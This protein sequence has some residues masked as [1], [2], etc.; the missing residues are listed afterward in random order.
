M[1]V[2]NSKGFAVS[3]LLYGL[4]IMG[5]LIVI[6]L[7]SIVSSNRV[8]TKNF[9]N[10]I[11]DDLNRYS[12]TE[13]S[14]SSKDSGDLAQEYFVPYGQEGWYKIELWGAGGGG[15]TGGKGAY[16]SGLIY[17]DA[18]THLYFYIGK[19]GGTS[20]A[21][22]NNGGPASGGYYGGGGETDVRLESGNSND[23]RS[24]KT[25]IMVAA[26]GGGAKGSTKGG[27]GG[28]LQGYKGDGTAGSAT[29]NAG[30]LPT[31]LSSGGGGGFR[32]GGAGEGGSSYISGYA[33]GSSYVLNPQKDQLGEWDWDYKGED[34]QLVP[35][36]LTIHY[37]YPVYKEVGEEAVLDRYDPPQHAFR[38]VN[39]LMI[40]GV[41]DGDGKANI[42]RVDLKGAT[43]LAKKDNIKLSRI[44]RIVD[45]VD[46]NSGTWK[47]IQAVSNGEN[48]IKSSGTVTGSGLANGNNLKDGLLNTEASIAGSVAEKC[49]T[50]TFSTPQDLDEIA[51][52]HKVGNIA[53]HNLEVC[54][55]SGGCYS[56]SNRTAVDNSPVVETS[57]G[58][59][60]SAYRGNETQNIANGT[61]LIIPVSNASMVFTTG[62]AALSDHDMMLKLAKYEANRYQM[63]DIQ[64]VGDNKYT[65]VET[66]NHYSLQVDTVV[67]N[68]EGDVIN[69]RARLVD[70]DRERWH[71]TP[72]GNGTYIISSFLDPE[73]KCC[74]LAYSAGNI[75][76]AMNSNTTLN[77]KFYLIN[78]DY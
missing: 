19:K 57:N 62:N 25:R 72:T 26:G 58:L 64:N 8:N 38:F 18:N 10:Q 61:Y 67:G 31:V 71:I 55:Q 53:K 74:R 15:A 14:F 42:E 41:N 56:L 37:L 27:N 40:P 13:V 5:F 23:D 43:E 3:T 36:K 50:V 54:D 52:W 35:G 24:M 11:E 29:Q 51:V 20:A 65:I 70:S 2:K 76:T 30:N 12:L 16:T 49:I 78:V 60:Y 66:Q 21:G 17:L 63:W 44:T 4:S 73:N 9:V 48:V 77:T 33:G 34:F 46:G 75:R 39:G 6:L 28:D 7:M 32:N 45:C 47:E 59:H 69:A 22:V 68:S 1:K